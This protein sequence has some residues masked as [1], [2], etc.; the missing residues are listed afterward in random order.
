MTRILP[1]L[2]TAVYDNRKL[3]TPD[4]V[5]VSYLRANGYKKWLDKILIPYIPFLVRMGIIT[6]K[7]KLQDHLEFNVFAANYYNY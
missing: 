4:A 3:N 6:Y 7:T 2:K 5:T 1:Q